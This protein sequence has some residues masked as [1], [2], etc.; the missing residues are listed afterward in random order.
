MKRRDFLSLATATGISSSLPF[1]S[2]KAANNNSPV[3]GATQSLYAPTRY[4]FIADISTYYIS[5]YDTVTMEQV[6]HLNFNIKPKV[7]EIARDDSM[8]AFGN[9]EVS[10]LY[11]YNLISREIK[12]ID[13][14]SPVYQIFFVPQSKLLAVG[15]RDQ[16]GMVNYDTGEVTIFPEKFDSPQRETVLYAYYT[17]LFS[18]FSQSFWVLDKTKPVIYRK[19][20]YDPIKK[21]WEVLDFTKRIRPTVGFDK[22]VASPEDYM[23][24]FNTLDGSEGLLY[25][26]ETDKLL[27]TG[28]MYT[29]GTTYRPMVSPYIDAYSQRVLFSDVSG[30]LAYFNLEQGDEK[31][32]RYEVDFSPRIIRSG[33]L[34]STWVIGGDKG[35][36]FQSFDNPDDHKIYR[37]PYEVVDMWVTGDSKTLYMTLD[38]GPPQIFRYDIRTREML[39][40]IRIKGVVMGGLLRMG[41]NNSICY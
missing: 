20:G 17:L 1:L 26:P 28:P 3:N 34:E 25:F 4:L 30:H 14:P 18:S 5:V 12:V 24:A 15:L 11:L 13:M 6:A 27:S 31:P 35:L 9:P 2:A 39:D 38:E 33:W 41:S 21:P 40:P 32:I 19:H 36:M 22:G 37:F 8:L 23:V 29:A 10:S 16:V 7:M